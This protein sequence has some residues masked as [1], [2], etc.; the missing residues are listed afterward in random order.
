MS[1]AASL[2][3]SLLWDTDLGLS[4]I[5]KYTYSAEE[6][7]KVGSYCTK[8]FSCVVLKRPLKAGALFATGMLNSG[9]R[10]DVDFALNLLSEYTENKSVPLKT[11]A[12]MGLA[13]A[14]AGSHREEVLA[15]LLPHVADD[16]VSMEISGMAALALGFVFAGSKHGDVSE[17]ILQTLMEKYER[18]DK[19]LDE[20]WAKFMV[21]GLG[22]LYLGLFFQ[23]SAHP[24]FH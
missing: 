16:T 17:T 7:I 20:K 6:H 10:T 14:Y 9:V 21:L 1:A 23:Y 5:D 13:L 11:S 4:H 8:E 2:G 15:L 24:P 18:A 19:S 3:L 12:F 22:L